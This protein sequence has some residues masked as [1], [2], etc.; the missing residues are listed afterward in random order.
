M[1]GKALAGIAICRQQHKY[2]PANEE[3]AQPIDRPKKRIAMKTIIALILACATAQA[4]AWDDPY[5][6]NQ[7]PRRPSMSSDYDPATGSTY[8]TQRHADGS[9]DTYGN[10]LNT[11]SSWNS[12]TDR[13]GNQSGTDASGNA[14][15]YNKDTGTYYNYG[16]GKMCTG[17]GAARFC[18]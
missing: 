10:N 15:N 6:Q 3:T 1:I 13:R 12:H 5:T 4:F 14:W 2:L 17:S 9:S 11:G 18:N 8:N 16:T 7:R